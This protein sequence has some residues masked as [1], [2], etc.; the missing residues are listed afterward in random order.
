MAL[1]TLEPGDILA[2][3]E[4]MLSQE[5]DPAQHP[6]YHLAAQALDRRIMPGSPEGLMARYRRLIAH[7]V[8][9]LVEAKLADPHAWEVD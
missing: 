1:K 2:E 9:R 3:L 8:A 5:P 4:S 6:L 7:A